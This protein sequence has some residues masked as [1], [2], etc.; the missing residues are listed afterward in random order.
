[1]LILL[2]HYILKC[3]KPAAGMQGECQP[4]KAPADILPPVRARSNLLSG[5]LA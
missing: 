4:G 5:P 1:M 2:F 3:T